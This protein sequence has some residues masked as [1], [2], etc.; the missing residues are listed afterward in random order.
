M[1][2]EEEPV[3]HL[4]HPSDAVRTLVFVFFSCLSRV[5]YFGQ[6]SFSPLGLQ[7]I[8]GYLKK[9]VEL[10]IFNRLL[11]TLSIIIKEGSYQ[12]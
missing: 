1:D 5:F 9:Q 11:S 4:V 8:S 12:L 7:L 6:M 3:D 10:S 2:M